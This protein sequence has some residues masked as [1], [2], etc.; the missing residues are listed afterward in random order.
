MTE[1]LQLA[2]WQGKDGWYWAFVNSSEP[3]ELS[4]ITGPYLTY[5]GAMVEGISSADE[6]V[7]KVHRQEAPDKLSRSSGTSRVKIGKTRRS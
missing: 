3:A 7:H 2:V 1:H 6:V 5:S 4:Q